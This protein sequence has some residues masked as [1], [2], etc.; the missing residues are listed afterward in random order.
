MMESSNIYNNV[1][2][3]KYTFWNQNKTPY[4]VSYG[5]FTPKALG[6]GT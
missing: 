2:E 4:I 3:G 1:I 6:H 5:M